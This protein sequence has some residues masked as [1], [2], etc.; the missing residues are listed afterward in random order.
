VYNLFKVRNPSSNICLD[1]MSKDEK[2]EFELGLFHCQG[3]KS[4]AE[5]WTTKMILPVYHLAYF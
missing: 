1:T 4:S 5:V 3:G 2:Y